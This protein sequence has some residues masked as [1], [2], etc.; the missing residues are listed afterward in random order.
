M[1]DLHRA[2]E[3]EIQAFT[4]ENTPPLSAIKERKR[5]HDRRRYAVTGA[6][7]SVLAFSGIA[8]A[9]SSL[10]DT[11]DRVTSFADGSAPT[12]PSQPVIFEVHTDGS[13]PVNDPRLGAG[14]DGCLDLP[15]TSDVA[16]FFT[17]PG[18]YHVTVT[19]AEATEEFRTCVNEVPGYTAEVSDHAGRP[20]P[21]PAPTDA[22]GVR[23]CVNLPSVS[24]AQAAD[25]VARGLAVS[26]L[27]AEPA[28]PD[29]VS[30]LAL[31]RTYTLTF[32]V[33]SEELPE[34][35]VPM[36]C[37]AVEAG[38]KPYTLP[39]P[40]LDQ[41]EQAYRAATDRMPDQPTS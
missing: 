15:G 12:A 33:G 28:S 30:C 5:S 40:A 26:F 38:G 24:C 10:T 4:P 22:T 21:L 32:Q 13:V 6:A 25:E 39:Q 14:L 3:A 7:L 19:G 1:S 36:I 18:T 23:I 29:M 27:D 31:G 8:L 35:R 37:G 11:T 2:V 16:M 41:V 9:S 20:A 17:L 34:I